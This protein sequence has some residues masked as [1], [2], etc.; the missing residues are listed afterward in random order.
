MTSTVPSEEP[1]RNR[2]L[3]DF[4]MK[5]VVFLTSFSSRD[6]IERLGAIKTLRAK[7]E[8]FNTTAAL[9]R[10]VEEITSGLRIEID[11]D[12]NIDLGSNG[13]L[14]KASMEES[15][16]PTYWTPLPIIHGPFRLFQPSAGAVVGDW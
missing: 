15:T 10:Q 5:G 6:H 3:L 7:E 11:I 8:V 13:A 4:V 9:D 12:T 2:K 16:F 14:K 1:E